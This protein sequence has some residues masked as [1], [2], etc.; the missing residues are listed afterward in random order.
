[1][2]NAFGRSSLEGLE[3][4]NY[5]YGGNIFSVGV[6]FNDFSCN[7]IRHLNLPQLHFVFNANNLLVYTKYKIKYGSYLYINNGW[8]NSE[9][10]ATYNNQNN[11]FQQTYDK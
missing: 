4:I 5:S 9:C 11:A 8:R 10:Q 6:I 1:M 7:G 3:K 2:K